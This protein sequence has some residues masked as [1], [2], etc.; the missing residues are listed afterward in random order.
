MTYHQLM[1]HGHLTSL[2]STTFLFGGLLCLLA[3]ACGGSEPPPK[4]PEPEP[5]PLE[6][7][8]GP[9][10]DMAMDE[11]ETEEVDAPEHESEEAEAAE[12]EFTDGM[13]VNE[14]MAAVPQNSEFIHIDQESLG[15]PLQNPAVYEPCKVGSKHFTL[16]VAV[17]DGRPVGVDVKSKDEKLAECVKSQVSQIEWPDKVKSLN[18]IG[19]GM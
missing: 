18:T 2:T 16:K 6:G 8:P 4:A 1:K 19:Y 9:E 7:P 3:A 10:T 15:K 13:S 11:V 17:W 14:A 5:Q 12:P